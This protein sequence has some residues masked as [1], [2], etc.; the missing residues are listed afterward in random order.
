MK[1]SFH[2]FGDGPLRDNLEILS[3]RLGTRNIVHFEG[4]CDDILARLQEVDAII[5]T[6]DHEGLPMILLEAMALGSTYRI[7]CY[8]RHPRSFWIMATAGSLSTGMNQWTITA[9]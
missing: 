7:T 2:I 6:S 9:R 8:W 4:H 1:Y 3:Q 5:I